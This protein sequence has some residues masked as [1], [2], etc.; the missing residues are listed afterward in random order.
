MQINEVFATIFAS[1]SD[2]CLLYMQNSMTRCKNA[3]SRHFC[4][5]LCHAAAAAGNGKNYI[6]LFIKNGL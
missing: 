5:S 6:F 2:T 3:I 4:N 1:L